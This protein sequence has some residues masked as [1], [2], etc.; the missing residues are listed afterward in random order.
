MGKE[1]S[2]NIL[3]IAKKVKKLEE[4][5]GSGGGGE[6]D[7][8]TYD[9]TASHLEATNVQDAIDE[10]SGEIAGLS[11]DDVSYDGTDSGL[12]AVTVQTAIDETVNKIDT[13]EAGDVDYDNTDSGLS[14]TTLQGAIDELNGRFNYSETEHIVGKW[15]DGSDLYEKTIDFGA[16]PNNTIKK[17]SSGLSNIT[18]RK[19]E[20]VG[21]GTGANVGGAISIPYYEAPS[22]ASLEYTPNNEIRIKSNIDVSLYNGYVTLHYTKNS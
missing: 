4:S 8:V 22:Y 9:H 10:L 17:A 20:G 2:L 16:L 3:E 5:G 21:I 7:D 15:I 14:A 19:M 18:I 11:A 13:L 12:S 6:A 1:L